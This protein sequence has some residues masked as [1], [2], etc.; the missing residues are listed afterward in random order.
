MSLEEALKEI[1]EEIAEALKREAAEEEAANK[2]D[3]EEV[4][5]VEEEKA[6]SEKKEDEK[7]AEEAK[8]EP[9]KE[10]PKEEEKLDDAGYA[11]LRRQAAA[12]EKRAREAE[13]R[14]AAKTQEAQVEDVEEQAAIPLSPELEEIVKDHRL[15]RAEREFTKLE[16]KF[17]ASEPEY[18]AISSQYTAALAASIKIQNP[19]LTPAE[20]GEKTKDALLH[21]AAA[22][23]RAGFDPIEELFHEAKELGFTGK[24]AKK[25]PE[26]EPKVV[27]K[28]EP[29]PDMKKLAENRAKSTGMAGASGKS[30]GQLTL[31]AADEMT[32]AEWMALP[33]SE[34]KRLMFP[35]SA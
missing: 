3:E 9:K 35:K 22:F 20:V 2:V 16:S 6:E 27:E 31:R 1:D 26:Q 5:P 24:A 21:K 25:E 19:R 33:L 15:S 8:E 12:A 29:R 17:A 4:A 10:E 11:R 23:V 30:E 18:D 34:R 14:L 7:P 32:N 13:E 28:E